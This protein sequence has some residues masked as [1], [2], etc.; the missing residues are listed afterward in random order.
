LPHPI[1]IGTLGDVRGDP[2]RF[3]TGEKIREGVRVALADC[4]AIFR[5]QETNKAHEGQGRSRVPR[6]VPRSSCRS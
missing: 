2:P 5:A 4:E 1:A 6:A 3:G